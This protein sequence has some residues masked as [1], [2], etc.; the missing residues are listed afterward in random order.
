M[1]R[2]MFRTLILC[3]LFAVV[4]TG[5]N[6]PGLLEY[7]RNNG[8]GGSQVAW[9]RSCQTCTAAECFKIGGANEA[10]ICYVLDAT[11]ALC[12]CYTRSDNPIACGLV[13]TQ[14]TCLQRKTQCKWINSAGASG[15]CFD[16]S[17][18]IR[19]NPCFPYRASRRTCLRRRGCA[20]WKGSCYM[21]DA[22]G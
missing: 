1:F 22:T 6:V 3:S 17:A 15:A 4:A 8:S 14:L 5:S 21:P 19:E 18:P 10:G 12:V 20:W 9:M 11:R 13:V 7:E 2:T 16:I